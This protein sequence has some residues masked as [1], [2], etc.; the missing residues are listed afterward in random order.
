MVQVLEGEEL[1]QYIAE[2][3]GDSRLELK[4]LIPLTTIYL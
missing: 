4:T 3:L 2:I 1:V